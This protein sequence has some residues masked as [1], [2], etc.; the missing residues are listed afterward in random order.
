MADSAGVKL[1]Q[2]VIAISGSGANEVASGVVTGIGAASVSTSVSGADI[3][4]GAALVN[5]RGDVVGLRVSDG[6]AAT[7]F[8]AASAAKAFAEA[9][10]A[11]P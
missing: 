4:P 5:L 2:S 11:S 3:L 7:T 10:S 6:S 1:A 8:A 9:P